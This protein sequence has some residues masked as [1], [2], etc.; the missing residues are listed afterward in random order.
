MISFILKPLKKIIFSV[1]N[2]KIR[3]AITHIHI[4]ILKNHICYCNPIISYQNLSNSLYGIVQTIYV[5]T[6][7]SAVPGAVRGYYRPR[8]FS[9]QL[10]NVVILKEFEDFGRIIWKFC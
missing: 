8:F 3:E 9:R 6:I 1:Q 5:V 4:H 10:K 2:L 7:N